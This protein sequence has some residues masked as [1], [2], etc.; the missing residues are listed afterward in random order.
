MV[1]V[2]KIFDTILGDEQHFATRLPTPLQNSC[3]FS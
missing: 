3:A 1:R 2:E